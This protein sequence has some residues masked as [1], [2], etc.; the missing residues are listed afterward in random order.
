MEELYKIARSTAE[1]LRRAHRMKD[2]F[3]GLISHELR[4]PLTTIYGNA[5][6]LRRHATRLDEQ[7]RD[8]AI[9][10]IELEAAK[11]QSIIENLLVLARFENEQGLETEPLL[12]LDQVAEIVEKFNQRTPDREVV[13]DLPSN[14]PPIASRAIYLEL[15]LANLLSNAHKYSPPSELIELTA[16]ASHG[17]VIISVR[18]YGVGLPQ[19]GIDQLFEPFRRNEEVLDVADGIGIGLATCKRIVEAHG[20]S[21]WAEPAEGRGSVFR[22]SL[23]DTDSRPR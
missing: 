15:V 14:L 3:L 16:Q 19:D 11:L 18:D 1:D 13:V 5:R 17:R 10:D 4:T 6:L 22:F 9:S 20:C 23:P 7:E 21:I 8:A 2:D 12:L